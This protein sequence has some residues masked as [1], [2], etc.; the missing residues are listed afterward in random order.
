[1]RLNNKK[2]DGLRREHQIR[3]DLQEP[4]EEEPETLEGA[5]RTYEPEPAT[6]WP[7]NGYTPGPTNR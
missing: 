5:I 1:M 7:T 3:H 2:N 4:V 6:I